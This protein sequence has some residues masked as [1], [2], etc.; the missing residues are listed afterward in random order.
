MNGWVKNEVVEE[1][2]H[3]YVESITKAATCIEDGIKTFTCS[4]GETYTETIPA[5]GHTY[6][7]VKSTPSTCTS[8][9]T[10]L[11]E[12]E[13]CDFSY[14]KVLPMAEH[15]Y[16]LKETVL[17]TCQE[18]GK[19]IYEC[20]ECGDTYTKDTEKGDHSYV[21]KETIPATCTED[22]KKIYECSV[23]GGTKEEAIA[24]TGHKYDSS[25]VLKE[26]TCKEDGEIEKTCSVCGDTIIEKIKGE[27]NY[28][29][30]DGSDNYVV[31]KEATCTENGEKTLECTVCGEA[32]PDADK[33]EIPALGHDWE[34]ITEQVKV[35]DKE[36]YDEE[37]LDHWEGWDECQGCGAQ[38]ESGSTDL[39]K[40]ILGYAVKDRFG[41]QLPEECTEIFGPASAT[42][43]K[44]AIYKTV[45]H[46]EVSHMETIIKGYK[47]TRCGETKS[48]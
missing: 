39:A 38:F 20:S 48:E 16:A 4:C 18:A 6:K 27:H 22:G 32:H 36:A 11:Y 17:G 5:T 45:H 31:T 12:C 19:E 14:S 42:N 8:F 34:A 24:H 1:H 21:L 15:K 29:K 46:D 40:H 43:K 10:E 47:C 37:V 9:G 33:V 26:A 13:N 3:N 41:N 28:K 35:V 25:K 23:C 2:K 44:E 30:A 7:L